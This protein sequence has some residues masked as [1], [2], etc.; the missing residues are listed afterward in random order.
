M[1]ALL[2]VWESVT[3]YLKRNK[4][5]AAL[6]L[7]AMVLAYG[8]YVTSY[9]LNVDDVFT[10][11]WNGGR[12]I[13]AGR[14][15]GYL[16]QL[17]TG[18][19]TYSPFFT[20]FLALCVFYF[21]GLTMAC[22]VNLNA[23]SKLSD[24]AVFVF[25]IV[26]V[27]Y[28]MISEQMVY[29]II[30]LLA[31]GYLMTAL[32]LW[33][34]DRFFET[35]SVASLITAV[36]LM[37]LYIDFYEAFAT[38]YLTLM[39]ATVLIR[40]MY[41]SSENDRKIVKI[42]FRMLKLTAVLAVAV[43]IRF[44]LAKAVLFAYYGTTQAGYGG[45]TSIYWG[46]I[47]VVDCVIW[48]IRTVFLRYCWAAVD[49]LPIFVFMVCVIAGGILSI[50]LTVRKKS[51]VPI[52]AFA[53]M[54]AGALS[55]NVLLGI[56]ANYTMA[57]ALA[58]FVAFVVTALYLAAEKKKAARVIVTVCI[59][60]LVLNQ[61]KSLNVWSVAN[62]ERYDYEMSVVDNIGQE[63]AKN[64]DIENKTVIFI[65]GENTPR[66]PE[67]LIERHESGQPVVKACQRLFLKLSDALLP[68]HYYKS[69]GDFCGEDIKNADD[70]FTYVKHIRNRTSVCSAYLAWAR[71]GNGESWFSAYE[72][73]GTAEQMY[74]LFEAR[75]YSLKRCSLKERQQYADL[76]S[77]LTAYPKDGYI[78]E[79]DGYLIVNFGS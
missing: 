52:L 77:D 68:E 76:Y 14:F 60:L 73:V 51:A 27:T 24:N 7:L 56:A 59:A 16:V 3:G 34:V 58:V 22:V 64:Y 36:V 66:L 13:A 45:N 67:S 79:R 74:Q 43:V 48:L 28:P 70:L 31:L 23:E 46:E 10:S 19:M 5:K 25:W 62:Y 69:I 30:L 33:F 26:F 49:Y 72:E 61:A 53:F 8:F 32:S 37:V 1:N 55:L 54:L 38:V 57:Q 20:M 29:P 2:P 47:G 4:V 21:A 35:K 9:T 12:L 75:G 42:F 78:T 44:V 50:V 71:G 39:M 6:V 41:A 40:F 11:F 17:L 18:F 65:G 63:L 15:T